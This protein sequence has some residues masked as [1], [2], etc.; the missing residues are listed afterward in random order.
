MKIKVKVREIGIFSA[1]FVAGGAIFGVVFRTI[2]KKKYEKE[3]TEVLDRV[4]E[5]EKL[6]RE[7]SNGVTREKSDETGY[8]S[9]GDPDPN[10]VN[11]VEIR[12][13][14]DDFGE[15]TI[16][17][18]KKLR[19]GVQVADEKSATSGGNSGKRSSFR[20]YTDYYRG[21]RRDTSVYDGE[22]SADPAESEHPE[23]DLEDED[24][25]ISE[26]EY[27]EI[28]AETDEEYQSYLMT[29]EIKQGHKEGPKIISMEA[30]EDERR[31][32]DK[33]QLYYYT[34]DE[35]L[36]DE[37]EDIIDDVTRVVGDALDKYD[38][39]NNDDMYVCVRN[40]NYST[41]YIIGKVLGSYYD[42]TR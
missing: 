34:D 36:A 35:I 7:A 1:G 9:E 37:N 17:E 11:R 19:E 31:D 39:R 42:L 33:V 3:V 14:E 15:L 24:D 8:I 10:V 22:N 18:Y 5:A 16:D 12:D 29:K 32:F 13:S 27:A 40:V 4:N 28:T 2:Y 26:D 6:L 30:F 41:D 38:F 20:A 21:I 25:D 23:D